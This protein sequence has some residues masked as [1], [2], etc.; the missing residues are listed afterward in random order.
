MVFLIG[1]VI[2]A[3]VIMA[4][5]DPSTRLCRWRKDRRRNTEAARYWVCDYCGAE[6]LTADAAPRACLRP[7]RDLP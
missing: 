1:L 6:T 4:T 5:H 3:V 7:K 2:V